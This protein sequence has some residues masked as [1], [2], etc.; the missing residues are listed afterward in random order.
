MEYCALGS[1]RD[2]I[3]TCGKPLNEEQIKFVVF[4]TLKALLYLHTQN[5]VH[6]FD[7]PLLLFGL[8]EEK[9]EKLSSN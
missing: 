7:T 9:R 4:H 3:V 8:L 5:I 6:R 1:I 2:M